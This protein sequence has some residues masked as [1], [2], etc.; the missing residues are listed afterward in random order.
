M[1]TDMYPSPS[2]TLLWPQCLLLLC[3]SLADQAVT[4]R[5]A[6][7]LCCLMMHCLLLY[8]LLCCSH[9][10]PGGDR[11]LAAGLP[12]PRVLCA[13]RHDCKRY[14]LC[15]CAPTVCVVMLAHFL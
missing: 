6:A 9:R 4:D 14:H 12:G 3:C 1:T 2:Q 15:R 11:P 8:C 13:Q 10:G 5:C 7:C